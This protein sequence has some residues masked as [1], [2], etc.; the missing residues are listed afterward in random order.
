MS[1]TVGINYDIG[2]VGYLDGGNQPVTVLGYRADIRL[3]GSTGDIRLRG[4][5]VQNDGG[6]KFSLVAFEDFGFDSFIGGGQYYDHL[7]TGGS[8]RS[9][10]MS[11]TLAE[12]DDEL[13]LSQLDFNTYFL[14]NE[15]FFDGSN[16]EGMIIDFLGEPS[17]GISSID[18]V[19]LSVLVSK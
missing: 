9:Y 3:T 5:K 19:T 16:N 4:R 15:N 14:A 12:T 13:T 6:K 1:A 17:G 11:V 10:T 18:H 7:R 8:D 2:K